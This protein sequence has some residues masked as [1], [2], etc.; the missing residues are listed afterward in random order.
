MNLEYF[1]T[2]Y[3]Y[4]YWANAR[5]LRATES[6]TSEEFLAPT[7][8]SHGS[9]RGTLLHTL[10]AE[11]VWLNRWQ[12]VSPK[13]GLDENDFSSFTVL[14]ARWREEEQKMQT[15]LGML[16]E[17]DLKRII[18]YTNT[19]GANFERPLWHMLVH[20]VNHG[21]QHRAEAAAILT[22]LGHSPGDMDFILFANGLH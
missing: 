1:Y 8:F 10:S 11:W 21:T 7:S 12:G 13:A 9:L 18:P 15:Y 20:V 14:R 19:R 3:N 4:N 5:I 22:S 16:H 6:V 2:L 17:S